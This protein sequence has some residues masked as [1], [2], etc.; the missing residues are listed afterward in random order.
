MKEEIIVLQ[1][2]KENNIP[3]LQ[4]V[5][6][7]MLKTNWVVWW[8]LVIGALFSNFVSQNL[9]KKNTTLSALGIL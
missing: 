1:V 8:E 9:E 3:D 2:Q 6:I 4:I 7:L 5:T